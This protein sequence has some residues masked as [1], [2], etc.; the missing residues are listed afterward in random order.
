MST[1]HHMIRLLLYVTNLLQQVKG[2][3][4]MHMQLMLLS[5]ASVI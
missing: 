2:R 1:S 4:N 3:H 5:I